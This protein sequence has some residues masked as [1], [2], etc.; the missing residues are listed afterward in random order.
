MAH[1]GALMDADPELSKMPDGP[2]KLKAAYDMAVYAR[3]DLRQ[4]FI[5]AEAQKK[6]QEA[7]KKRDAERAKKVTS[8]KPAAG[9]VSTKPKT[10]SLDDALSQ[11]M[12]KA[13][14]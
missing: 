13:G 2:D 6:I 11:A 10:N 7:Q 1:M 4:S 8:V 3:K 12:S 14:L 5:E 9:V